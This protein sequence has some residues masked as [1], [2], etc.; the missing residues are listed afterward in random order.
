M[1]DKTFFGTGHKANLQWLSR[2]VEAYKERIDELT[3]DVEKASHIYY[4]KAAAAIHSMCKAARKGPESEEFV[5]AAT[6][7]MLFLSKPPVLNENVFPDFL[8]VA[9]KKLIVQKSEPGPDWWQLL[10]PV[11]WGDSSMSLK[12]LGDLQRDSIAN[13]VADLQN[14]PKQFKEK[15]KMMFSDFSR[16]DEAKLADEV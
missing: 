14:D 13:K 16:L 6:E 8:R 10:S 3:D 11:A 7:Q 5:D 2:L 4:R 1:D 9:A 12:Q 15:M